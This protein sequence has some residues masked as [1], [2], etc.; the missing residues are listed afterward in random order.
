MRTLQVL[1]PERKFDLVALVVQ[2]ALNTYQ[3]S[4]KKLPTTKYI[5]TYFLETATVS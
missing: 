2:V 1:R 4:E 3:G 5:Y